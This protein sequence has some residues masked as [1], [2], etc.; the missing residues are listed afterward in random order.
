MLEVKHRESGTQNNHSV[1]SLESNAKL[2][3]YEMTMQQLASIIKTDILQKE[4]DNVLIKQEIKFKT[5]CVIYATLI[6]ANN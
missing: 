4:P 3:C 5:G 6:K 1:S 2:Q